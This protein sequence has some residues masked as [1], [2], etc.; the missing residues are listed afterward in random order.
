MSTQ[1][2][3]GARPARIPS[4]PEA[5]LSS[6]SS[7]GSD[8]KT[9]SAAS[10]TSRGVSRQCRPSSMRS[11]GVRRGALLAVDRCSRRRGSG[12]P[13][14]RPCA[15]GRRSR[16]WL[17]S[18]G[19]HLR[20]GP[21][22]GTP[23]AGLRPMSA[24][25]PRGDTPPPAAIQECEGSQEPRT[26]L[27]RGVALGDHSLSRRSVSTICDDLRNRLLAGPVALKL[28]GERDPADGLPA[29]LATRSRPA[30][31]A[32]TEV[33]PISVDD[34]ID[35]VALTE[36]IERGEGQADLRPESAHDQLASAG[37]ATAWRNSGSSHELIV[38]RSTAGRPR[39]APRV[40]EGSAPGGRK[41]R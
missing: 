22:L 32:S 6:T 34:R 15:R 23:S 26:R 31:W 17:S 27:S 5:T 16:W 39:A 20:S 33:P 30:R 37:R 24:W 36:C 4:G 2:L 10:A 21:M 12:R 7:S 38:V 28:A 18:C 29:S 40:P 35:V 3:P 8:V 13:C 14:S 9:M 25:R 41:R 19:H 1:I 11:L